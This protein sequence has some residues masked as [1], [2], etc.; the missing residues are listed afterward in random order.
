MEESDL[1]SQS[2]SH[3]GDDKPSKLQ[4]VH[5]QEVVKPPTSEAEIK[6]TK[7]KEINSRISLKMLSV[8]N[9]DIKGQKREVMTKESNEYHVTSRDTNCP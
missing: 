1:E 5:K 4:I 7:T 8:L 2:L 3:D 9:A 6:T